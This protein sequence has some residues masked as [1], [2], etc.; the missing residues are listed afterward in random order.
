MDITL[1]QPL[2]MTSRRIRLPFN[3]VSQDIQNALVAEL[4]QTENITFRQA[5]ELLGQSW[6][7]TANI[8]EEHGC[9]LYYD[10][11]DFLDDRKTFENLSSTNPA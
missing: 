10:E 2:V 4:Y 9:T 8:L 1:T 5:Q 7:R 6:E 11:D 3:D